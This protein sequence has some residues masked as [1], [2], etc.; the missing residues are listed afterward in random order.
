MTNYNTMDSNTG[1]VT[2]SAANSNTAVNAGINADTNTDR[3][4]ATPLGSTTEKKR[5]LIISQPIVAFKV[6]AVESK[7]ISD[8]EQA[9]DVKPDR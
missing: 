5:R 9:P 8:T 6:I 4:V 7:A 2:G 1:Q 3:P